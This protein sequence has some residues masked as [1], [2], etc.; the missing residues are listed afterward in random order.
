M[1]FGDFA[2]WIKYAEISLLQDFDI[3]TENKISAKYSTLR[4]SEK[5]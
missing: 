5:Y 4:V 3:T 1:Y 2:D